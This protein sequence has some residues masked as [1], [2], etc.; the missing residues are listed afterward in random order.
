MALID[1]GLGKA[2]KVI[3]V[4]EAARA[5]LASKTGRTSVPSVWIGDKYIGGCNDGPKSWMGCLPNLRKGKVQQWIKALEKSRGQSVITAGKKRKR[6]SEDSEENP[7]DKPLMTALPDSM[8]MLSK[9]ELRQFKKWKTKKEAMPEGEDVID[10]GPKLNKRERARL[11]FEQKGGLRKGEAVQGKSAANKARNK[12]LDSLEKEELKGLKIRE[13]Q[14]VKHDAF[15]PPSSKQ[16]SDKKTRMAASKS[17]A[18]KMKSVG[19]NG[20]ASQGKLEWKAR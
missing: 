7:A 16:I 17:C 9:K 3:E 15:R 18:R 6:P 10:N 2:A 14:Q 12:V 8:R 11:R 1:A 5:E 20:G 19:R 4:N 13:K